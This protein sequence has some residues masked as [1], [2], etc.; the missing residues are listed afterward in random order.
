MKKKMRYIYALIS[1]LFI[2]FNSH[3]AKPDWSR[4]DCGTADN[5]ILLDVW[6]SSGTDIFAVGV[7]FQYGMNSIIPLR[8]KRLV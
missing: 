7:D 3:L 2:F 6:G 5:S 1:I 8:W 4:M